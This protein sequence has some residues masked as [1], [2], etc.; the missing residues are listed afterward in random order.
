MPKLIMMVGESASGKSTYAKG[1]V[2]DALQSKHKMIRIN[3]DNLRGMFTDGQWKP[4]LEKLVVSAEKDIAHSALGRGYDVIIDDTNLT[5]KHEAMWGEFVKSTESLLR[6]PIDFVIK[7]M[8][9]PFMDCVQRDAQR[10][11]DH[12]GRAVIEKQFVMSGRAEFNRNTVYAIVDVDGTLANH[13]GVR[14]V[15]DESKVHLDKP[16]EEI[17]EYVR[18]IA[19]DH[20]IIIVSGRHSSCCRDTMRWINKQYIPI[21]HIFM[22]NTGDSRPDTIVKQEILDGILKYIDKAQIGQVVDDR[23]CVIQMWRKNGLNVLAARGEDLE[24]F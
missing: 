19:I 5:T 11:E 1:L 21:N 9:T 7:R 14:S 20:K 2:R 6:N 4:E 16:Y 10:D 23:P 12:V 3:R 15:Y 13:E 17:C 8:D 18:G 24:D 22:R